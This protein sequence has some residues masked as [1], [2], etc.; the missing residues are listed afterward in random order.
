MRFGVSVAQKS[1]TTLRRD[2]SFYL[3]YAVPIDGINMN[4]KFD[5]TSYELNAYL[6]TRYEYKINIR[7][8][9]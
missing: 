4:L 3:S 7:G 1:G 9:S 8:V 6:G 5:Q 2:N